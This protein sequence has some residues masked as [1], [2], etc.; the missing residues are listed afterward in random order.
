MINDE[1]VSE[2][3][4]HIAKKTR[5]WKMHTIQEEKTYKHILEVANSIQTWRLYWGSRPGSGE[6]LGVKGEGSGSHGVHGGK[7]NSAGKS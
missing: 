2:E 4:L 7:R 5:V 3:S 1:R 6:T